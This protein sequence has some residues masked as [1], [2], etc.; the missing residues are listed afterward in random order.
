MA[1]NIDNISNINTL[2][3]NLHN[4][5]NIL[6]SELVKLQKNVKLVEK[7][8]NKEIK[9]LNKKSNDRKTRQKKMPS[10]FAVPTKVTNELCHFLNK[11]QGTKMARTDV[12]KSIIEYINANNLQ[13]SENKQVIVPDDKLKNL[14]GTNDKEEVTYF[15]LQKYMN[16]HFIKNEE[17]CSNT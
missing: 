1:Q 2:F 17:A 13:F 11:E 6:K 5:I 9:R 4:D 8:V 10:G 7:G 16:K 12:T 3:I 15:N 14:L